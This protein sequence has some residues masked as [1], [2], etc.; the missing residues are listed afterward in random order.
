M[1]FTTGRR[2]ARDRW[3]TRAR[4]CGAAFVFAAHFVTVAEYTIIAKS[5]AQF[6]YAAILG[7]IAGITRAFESIEAVGVACAFEW[8]YD[9]CAIGCDISR[10]I[11]WRVGIGRRIVQNVRIVSGIVWKLYKI[12]I[13]ARSA[14]DKG[15]AHCNGYDENARRTSAK[16]NTRGVN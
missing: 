6:A 15:N 13:A 14:C 5:I 9:D 12:D 10:C 7:E 11:K 4:D 3:R 8:S 1:I 16:S 2:C